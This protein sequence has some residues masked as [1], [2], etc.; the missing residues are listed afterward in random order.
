MHNLRGNA[1]GKVSPND[2][3]YFDWFFGWLTQSTGKA[4]VSVHRECGRLL[5]SVV[6]ATVGRQGATEAIRFVINVLDRWAMREYSHDELDSETLGGLYCPGPRMKSERPVGQ[7]MLIER[8]EAVKAI[9]RN[10]Y[11]DE[12]ALE[13]LFRELDR[14]IVSIRKW[15]GKPRGKVYCEPVPRV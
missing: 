13:K 7:P 9:L 6:Q 2:I 5:H 4:P 14:G 10:Y 8:L 15:D 3:Q 12:P 11:P 1:G